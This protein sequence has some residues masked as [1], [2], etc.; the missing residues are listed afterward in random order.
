MT[1]VL[2][3]RKSLFGLETD[4][5]IVAS[6]QTEAASLSVNNLVYTDGSSNYKFD[7]TNSFQGQMNGVTT[8]NTT[9][10]DATLV[11]FIQTMKANNPGLDFLTF[12]QSVTFDV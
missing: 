5:S 3:M 7:S 2:I 9:D 8:Y 12:S 6:Y 10:N 4:S 11:L 1:Q